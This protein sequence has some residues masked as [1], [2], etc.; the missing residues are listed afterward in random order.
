[1]DNYTCHLLLHIA[2]DA[3]LVA[4]ARDVLQKIM[5][6]FAQEEAVRTKSTLAAEDSKQETFGQTFGF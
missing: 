3:K 1:M 4:T 2:A 6:D 5:S